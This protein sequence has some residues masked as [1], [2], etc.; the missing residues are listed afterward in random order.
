MKRIILLSD[1]LISEEEGEKIRNGNYMEL[2]DEAICDM[3]FSN[4]NIIVLN[5]EGPITNG[6]QKQPKGDS[7]NVKSSLQSVKFLKKIPNF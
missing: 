6:I 2:F 5:L 7:P 1:F 4:D 3:L